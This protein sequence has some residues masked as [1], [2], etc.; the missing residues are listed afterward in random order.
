D[1]PRHSALTPGHRPAVRRPCAC[2]QHVISREPP[3]RAQQ[4]PG[5]T[6][7]HGNIAMAAEGDRYWWSPHPCQAKVR[8]FA[9]GDALCPQPRAPKTARTTQKIS[10]VP[11]LMDDIHCRIYG[12]TLYEISRLGSP[13]V[14]FF[15]AC[16]IRDNGVL[17]LL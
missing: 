6:E 17:L 10:S 1:L 5:P 2:L 14:I 13:D 4:L 11:L 12:A 7:P 8:A 9:G 16:K 15:L 3:G